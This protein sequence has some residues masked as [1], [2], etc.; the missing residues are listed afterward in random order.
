MEVFGHA[1]VDRCVFVCDEAVV[2]LGHVPGGVDVAEVCVA[3]MGAGREARARRRFPAMVWPARSMRMSIWSGADLCGDVGVFEGGDVAPVVGVGF[4]AVGDG[5]GELVGGVAEDFEL[6]GVVKR[7][8]VFDEE[9]DGVLA[10]VGGEVADAEAARG[11]AV[12]GVGGG[13]ELGGVGVAF[14]SAPAAVETASEDEFGGLIQSV[15]EGEEVGGEDELVVGGAIEVMAEGREG[16][17]DLA[18]VAEGDGDGGEGV[19]EVGV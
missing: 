19:E 7:E 18:E 9:G 1:R 4:E 11:G 8:E 13:G 17:V 10:E 6:G 5:V 2:D 3:W 12:V 14:G 15:F 16:F